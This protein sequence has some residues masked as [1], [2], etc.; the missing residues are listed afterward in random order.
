[1][2][3]RCRRI[4]RGRSC[5]RAILPKRTT[6]MEC[7]WRAARAG[8]GAP[9]M[10]V[11]NSASLFEYD[12]PPALTAASLRRHH[13]VNL[14]AP[15]RC[16]PSALAAQ[17]DLAERGGGQYPRS[18]ACQSEPRFLFVQLR[19]DR[20][21]RRVGVMLAQALGPAHPRQ[22]RVAGPVAAECRPDRCRIRTR[23]RPKTCCS[24][25]SIPQDIARAV[26]FLLEARG[27]CRGRTC[28]S[29]AGNISFQ[30]PAM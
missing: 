7:W 29:I 30:V 23:L 17:D 3:R 8:F 28:S 4:C 25:R 12:T 14:E 6:P 26:A 2:P 1:M 11:V 19:Q 13:A 27:V 20:A 24:V 5:W 18:E 10:A 9:L 22:R 15:V 16:S 21:G